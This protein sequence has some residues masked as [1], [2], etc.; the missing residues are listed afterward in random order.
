MA[1]K[2]KHTTNGWLYFTEGV[3][4]FGT[5]YVTRAM[6]N[7]LGPGWNRPQDAVYPISQHD[8]D[9]NDYDGTKHRY[10]MRFE[11]GQLPPA[12][13]FWSVT[14]YDKEMFFVPNAIDRYGARPARS[15]HH[16]R[17]QYGGDERF[18]SR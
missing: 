3:G 14:L 16:R 18:L 7:L 5:D 4:N 13:A 10:V 11:E 6:A 12:G 17:G 15:D 2:R 1:L 8:P 9:G